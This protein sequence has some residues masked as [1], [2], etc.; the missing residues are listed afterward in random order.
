MTS[1][2]GAEERQRASAASPP[3][4]DG[5]ERLP[6]PAPVRPL[7]FSLHVVALDAPPA[8]RL[9]PAGSAP[10]VPAARLIV[11]RADAGSRAGCRLL[12]ERLG[13][14]WSGDEAAQVAVTLGSFAGSSGPLAVALSVAPPVLQGRI[15]SLTL[16][17]TVPAEAAPG[18]YKAPLAVRHG[19]RGEPLAVL[20]EVKPG[21]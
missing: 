13:G 17:V 2:S 16:M 8:G 14:D 7:R 11:L 6:D 12:L 20:L 5:E 10:W 4:S 21:A 9:L 15:M 1:A 18:R 19:R 3:A